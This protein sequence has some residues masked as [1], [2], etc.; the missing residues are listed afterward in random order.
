M[1]VK[2]KKIIFPRNQKCLPRDLFTEMHGKSFL[3]FFSSYIITYNVLDSER[4]ESVFTTIFYFYKLSECLCCRFMFP[5]IIL[6]FLLEPN[7]LFFSTAMKIKMP[8]F[9]NRGRRVRRGGITVNG[10]LVVYPGQR[11]KRSKIYHRARRK[12]DARANGAHQNF[13][14]SKQPTN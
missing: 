10:F 8:D 3:S 5:V 6:F 4:N 12:P 14:N 11:L 9:A 2:K 13:C 1:Y 7:T